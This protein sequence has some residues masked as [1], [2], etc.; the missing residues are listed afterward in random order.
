M[1]KF[2]VQADLEYEKTNNARLTQQ[3]RRQQTAALDAL[4]ALNA[5]KTALEGSSL[6]TQATSADTT[7]NKMDQQQQPAS[8]PFHLNLNQQRETR[9]TEEDFRLPQSSS[10][11][12]KAEDC[13]TQ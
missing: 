11:K 7:D 3:I 6:V 12:A 4:N 8:P 9:R 13:K 2:P 10:R 1:L 5:A